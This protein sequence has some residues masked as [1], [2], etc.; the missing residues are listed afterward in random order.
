MGAGGQ[1]RQRGPGCILSPTGF[2]RHPNHHAPLADGLREVDAALE[3]RPAGHSVLQQLVVKLVARHHQTHFRQAESRRVLP[4]VKVERFAG[5][6][7]HARPG[8]RLVASG[9]QV[10]KDA[11]TRQYGDGAWRQPITA[12]LVAREARPVQ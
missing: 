4:E 3:T 6:G 11:E 10:A 5:G 1:D 8:D 9:A 12:R 7:H 2:S